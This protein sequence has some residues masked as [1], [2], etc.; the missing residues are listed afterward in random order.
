VRLT[1]T[2]SALV[3]AHEPF[4]TLLHDDGVQVYGTHGRSVATH[5][6]RRGSGMQTS[7]ITGAKLGR[8]PAVKAR[9]TAIRSADA[10]GARRTPDTV[11]GGMTGLTIRST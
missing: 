3:E 7:L 8:H 5:A 10:V 2:P 4:G 11:K 9:T 1:F 6:A